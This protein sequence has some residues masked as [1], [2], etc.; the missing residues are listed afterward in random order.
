VDIRTIA[1]NSPLGQEAQ[2]DYRGTNAPDSILIVLADGRIIS[3]GQHDGYGPD[4]IVVHGPDMETLLDMPL[5]MPVLEPELHGW[6]AVLGAPL[7]GH[8]APAGAGEGVEASRG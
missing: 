1:T 7:G 8:D 4:H 2:T 6:D 3:I 5:S